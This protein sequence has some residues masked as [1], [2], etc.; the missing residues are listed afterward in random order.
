VISGPVH[1][2]IDDAA[3]FLHCLGGD[4]DDVSDE[5]RNLHGAMMP[6]RA[7]QVL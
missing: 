2:G 3:H 5:D 6:R 7:A 4:I 1:H